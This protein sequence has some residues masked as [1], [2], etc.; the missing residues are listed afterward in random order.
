MIAALTTAVKLHIMD[1]K[2]AP[3]SNLKLPIQF[4]VL[5]QV[6]A[7]FLTFARMHVRYFG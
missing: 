6:S 4:F 7:V 2:A 5:R 1:R 3:S